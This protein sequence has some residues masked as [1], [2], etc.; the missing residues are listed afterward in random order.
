MDGPDSEVAETQ[1]GVHWKEEPLV[2]LPAA[3]VAQANMS[4]RRIFERFSEENFPECFREY[5][6]L[7]T[8]DEKWHAILDTSNPPFW[9]WFVGGR[10]N[11]AYN[12]VD[13]HLTKYRN[14]AAIIWVPEPED[15][16]HTV[17]TYQELYR[18]VNEFALVLQDLGLKAG[19]RVTFHLP[20]TPEL[21]ISMLACARLGIIHNE[22]FGGFS[23]RACAERIEDSKS[24]VLVTID[25]YYRNGRVIDKKK[26][27]DV[28]VEEAGRLGA[29]VEKVLVWKRHPGR[30]ISTAPM[31]EGRDFFVDD[32]GAPFRSE[33]VA[34]VSMDSEAPLFLMYTSGSTGK[35]K[36][37]QHRTGGYLAYV[38]ATSK[39]VQDI[40]PEDVYW[41]FAD[42]GWI[43]GHSYI[44]YG[45]LALAATTVMYEGVPLYPDA[46]RPW[47]IAERLGVNIFHT[48]PTTIRMLRKS[49]PGEPL[50][51]DYHF[52]AM[53]TVG[54][55][56]EPETWRW[57]YD[58]VGK[59]EAVITD[60]WWQTETGGFLCSTLPAISPMKPG[61]AGPGMPGIYPV[62]Y[63][64]GGAVIS[65]GEKRAGNLCIRNPWPGIMQTIWGDPD[66]FVRTYYSKYN[67]DR[68][69][70]DWHDWPY[71]SG[72]GAVL[73][74]DG[75]FRILGRIDDVIKV[76][77]HRLG[78]KE[79]ENAVLTTPEVA[80][81]AAIAMSDEVR[82]HVPV[83]YAALKPGGSD[84][85]P[86]ALEEAIKENVVK[87][88]GPIARPRSVYIVPDLP[89]TRSGKIMR[90]VLMAISD[91]KDDYGDITTLA[92]PDVVHAIR[93][94]VQSS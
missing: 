86:K 60:T 29:Q 94:L 51:Y 26:E 87:Q 9:K 79:L 49:G 4:D 63:D 65:A 84:V 82:G 12:C 17:I 66:R 15:E 6:D 81:A 2:G 68:G 11:A 64:E 75:Y 36:G 28:V 40:H 25:G 43:T 53:T 93:K 88:L 14:K 18:R 52:K 23:A 16:A 78:T 55:P 35:P 38:A 22:V 89:K 61:S 10:L 1:I 30:Y 8:W 72:D 57:F 62:I 45:P 70:K 34:P 74:S 54:E 92:N 67:R 7:L 31:V 46:G 42:I 69:S 19:D 77:G 90:R 76:A 59:K 27:A 32:L 83:V 58:V 47:R 50:K 13:R 71:F 41:C 3:F 37:A 56:I 44:V 20:M 5:A 39:Y 48:A 73:A 33:T 21:P 24:G 85:S 80:E 91:R